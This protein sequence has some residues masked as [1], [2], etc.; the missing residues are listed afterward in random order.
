MIIKS[1]AL[2]LKQI[3]DSGQAFRWYEKSDHYIVV[4]GHKVVK[5]KQLEEG[6]SINDESAFWSHYLDIS[7]DYNEIMT[8]YKG[9]DDFLDA[10]IDYG[11]GIR[12]LNQDPFEMTMTFII[13]ANNNIKR[14]TSAIKML[15]EQYG[16]LLDTIDGED[17]YDF[18]SPEQLKDVSIE[19]Y[20]ACGVGYRDRYLF[21]CVKDII[22][23]NIDLNQIKSL[24]DNELKQQLLRLKG[25]GEKVCNCIVLFGY[26]RYD[27]FPVDT[28]IR[29][30]LIEK[31]HINKDFESFANDY[32]KPFGGI[33]QQ[34]LFYYGRTIKL[35]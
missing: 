17:Y 13:S 33:A 1:N 28:W 12:I 15:S 31:Y 10:A 26:A 35:T 5:M 25:V 18:P 14:I 6:I 11:S 24:P 7:R 19:D 3:A 4:A 27:S 9:K 8:F 30:V 34:Y 32:F 23:K 2:N 29:K 20:R 16:T 21:C 22:E